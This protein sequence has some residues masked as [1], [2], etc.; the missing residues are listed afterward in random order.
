MS[1][2]LIILVLEPSARHKAQFLPVSEGVS[3]SFIGLL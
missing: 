3:T 2:A 1:S